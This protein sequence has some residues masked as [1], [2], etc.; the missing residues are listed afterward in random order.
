M[1]NHRID[2]WLKLVCLFKHRTDASEACRGGHVK[3]NGQR[4]KPAARLKEGDVVEF[5]QGDHYRRVVVAGLPATS[6][7]KETARTMYV[8][9][10]PRQEPQVTVAPGGFRDRGSGRPTKKDR[11]DM[12]KAGRWS[13]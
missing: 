9:E 10:T 12:S 1:E 2:H 6:I 11:R 3:I 7:S 13:S 8:D 4:A 5:L